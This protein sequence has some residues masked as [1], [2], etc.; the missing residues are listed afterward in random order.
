M[1]QIDDTIISLDIL[2]KTFV[3][4]LDACKGACCVEGDSGAPLEGDEPQQLEQVYETVKK[5]M[6]PDGI[7]A[8]KKQGYW[9]VDFEG[10]KVTPLVDNKH[11]AYLYRDEKNTWM[12]AIEKAWLNGEV[13]FRKPISCHLYP[14]R[15][16]KYN[17]FVAV[18]Y[19]R[20]NLCTPARILGD[21]L[22]VPMYVFLKEPLIRKF[23]AEWYEQLVLSVDELKQMGHLKP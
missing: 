13:T 16:A 5:Y 4:N 1:L 22:G 17:D 15:V 12:C 7:A 19:E 20:N 6:A 9:V 14:I 18:N 3:C 2:D 11:C 8:I 21:K 10:D 23:G